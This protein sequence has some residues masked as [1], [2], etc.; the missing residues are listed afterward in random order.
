[1]R[2][3]TQALMGALS[4]TA[5]ISGWQMGASAKTNGFTAQPI[6]TGTP[7]GNPTVTPTPTPTV[8]PTKSPHHTKTPTPTPTP[9]TTPTTQPVSDTVSHTSQPVYYRY[10]TVQLTVT[11]KGSTI[12]DITM[13]QAGATAGRGAAFPYLIQLAM[14]A[15]SSNFDTSMMSGA[16]FTTMAFVQALDDALNQF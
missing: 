3:S 16:T 13:D 9:T 15:Q 14:N 5:V 4:L 10:G 12:T 2:K 8:H 7:T 1:M 11:K 6:P